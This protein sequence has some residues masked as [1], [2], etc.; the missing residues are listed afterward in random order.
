MNSQGDQRE[1]FKIFEILL[2]SNTHLLLKDSYS[3]AIEWVHISQG[4][5]QRNHSLHYMMLSNKQ[6]VKNGYVHW[7]RGSSVAWTNDVLLNA[8]D[9]I[10]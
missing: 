3:V 1:N 6:G 7:K 2:C 9:V 8:C 4:G 5:A 10:P